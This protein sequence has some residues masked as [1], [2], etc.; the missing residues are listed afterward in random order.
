MEFCELFSKLNDNIEKL[1][2]GV[3]FLKL[4]YEPL[5][6]QITDLSK[7][8]RETVM[9]LMDMQAKMDLLQHKIKKKKNPEH[10]IK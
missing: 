7:S 10:H 5:S 9:T 6:M 1:T 8:N 4:S 2:N 3:L